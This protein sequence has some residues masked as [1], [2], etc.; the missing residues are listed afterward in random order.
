MVTKIQAGSYKFNKF[1]SSAELQILY[2]LLEF[3]DE[4]STE[5]PLISTSSTAE[6]L[7]RHLV[8]NGPTKG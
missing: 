3:G 5:N 2:D 7:K 4:K 8:T 1:A 6:T